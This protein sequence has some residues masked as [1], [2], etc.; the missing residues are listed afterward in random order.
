VEVTTR[1]MIDSTTY[2][3]ATA[4]RVL[5]LDAIPSAVDRAKETLQEGEKLI[6][7]YQ[8]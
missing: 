3:A 7:A 1:G 5:H 2:Y 6:T 8:K 4:T